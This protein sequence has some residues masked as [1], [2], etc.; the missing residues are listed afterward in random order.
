MWDVYLGGIVDRTWRETF[1]N[2]I[3]ADIK[4][5]DPVIDKYDTLN[6]SERANE[7]AREVLAAEKCALVVFYL[8]S[9][10]LGQ[11]N[12]LELGDAVGRG[13]QVVVCLVDKV[14]GDEKIRRYCELQGVIVVQSLDELVTTVEEYLAE[15][16]MC[17]DGESVV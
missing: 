5:F 7:S 6:E 1:K 3:S 16:A 9:S 8:D 10:W 13:K 17:I 15:L 12:M 4:V 2:T 14:I 11:S